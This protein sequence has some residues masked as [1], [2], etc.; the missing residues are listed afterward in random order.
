MAAAAA[1]AA[2]VR[3]CDVGVKR[4]R[5]H[6]RRDAVASDVQTYELLGCS[7]RNLTSVVRR[8]VSRRG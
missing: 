5:R 2:A 6:S 1:A 3:S 7:T 8:F 4:D